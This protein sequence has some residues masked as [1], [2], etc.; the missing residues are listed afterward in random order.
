VVPFSR[1]ALDSEFTPTP[2]SPSE[3]TFFPHQA[4][5]RQEL[6]VV[7]NPDKIIKEIRL[8][9]LV[10]E[11]VGETFEGGRVYLDYGLTLGAKLSFPLLVFRFESTNDLRYL[12]PDSDDRV[13]DLAL[14]FQSV[15]RL[16]IPVGKSFQF[17]VF[18]DF[19]SVRGKLPINREFG[20]S[21]V[22]G[23]GLSFDRT[24]RF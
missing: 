3:G 24:L 5:I 12:V 2:R 10:Q 7:A 4:L 23:G 20:F 21:S 14:R 22:F 1:L 18:G 16:I 11:D 8:G 17:F 6:G 13:Q 9:A 15:N 19:F